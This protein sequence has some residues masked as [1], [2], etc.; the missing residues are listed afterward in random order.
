MKGNLQIVIFVNKT[1][2]ILNTM[3]RVLIFGLVLFLCLIP[4]INLNAQAYRYDA[5]EM[6]NTIKFNVVKWNVNYS[7]SYLDR[8]FSEKPG[9]VTDSMSWL[10]G[11]NEDWGY[12]TFHRFNQGSYTCNYVRTRETKGN[13]GYGANTNISKRDAPYSSLKRV[14]DYYVLDLREFKGYVPLYLPYSKEHN[15]KVWQKGALIFEWYDDSSAGRTASSSQLTSTSIETAT[16]NAAEKANESAWLVGT[17]TVNTREF[18]RIS[19][20]ISGNGQTGRL[21]F[22]GEKGSYEVKGSEIRC[23]IDGDPKDLITVFKIHPGNR[24]YFGEG[25]YFN[26]VK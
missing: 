16:S 8:W 22:D 15:R 2:I 21:N 20:I 13:D 9:L 1:T 6:D 4:S 24:I 11:N 12:F 14:G 7:C 26:K 25:Y 18:G 10:S 3:K 17:W 23:H 5:T 19:L